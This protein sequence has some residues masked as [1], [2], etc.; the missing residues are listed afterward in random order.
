MVVAAFPFLSQYKDSAMFCLLF[1]LGL[2]FINIYIT[3]IFVI[4]NVLE[5]TG[6]LAYVFNMLIYIWHILCNVSLADKTIT[7]GSAKS[8]SYIDEVMIYK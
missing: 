4:S 5:D 2:L 3:N 6:F 7:I 1:H 8:E